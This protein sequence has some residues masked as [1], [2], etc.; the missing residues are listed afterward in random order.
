M[1]W[2]PLQCYYA[3]KHS[4]NL[5]RTLH[6]TPVPSQDGSTRK[7][8]PACSSTRHRRI[9]RHHRGK[10]AVPVHWAETMTPHGGKAPGQHRAG[11]LDFLTELDTRS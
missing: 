6:H 5:T 9:C 8:A 10:A 4:C 2:L 11:A 7:T 3:K 1:S